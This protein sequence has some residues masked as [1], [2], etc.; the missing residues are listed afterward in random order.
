MAAWPSSASSQ[1][2]PYNAQAF[3]ADALG[4]LGNN[5]GYSNVS[6]SGSR[7]STKYTS[8][9]H[10]ISSY[11]D[12]GI[13]SAVGNPLQGR[14]ISAIATGTSVNDPYYTSIVN[15]AIGQADSG[16]YLTNDSFIIIL[17]PDLVSQ[18]PTVAIGVDAS[19]SVTVKADGTPWPTI[20]GYIDQPWTYNGSWNA[21]LDGQSIVSGQALASLNTPI[22]SINGG[23]VAQDSGDVFVSQT[24]AFDS[25]GVAKLPFNFLTS[26]NA[27]SGGVTSS[28]SVS[29]SGNIDLV[30]IA[31]L[32]SPPP[33]TPI[34]VMAPDGTTSNIIYAPSDGTVQV[35]RR[36]TLLR[37]VVAAK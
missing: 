34:M 35:R 37:R 31:P 3:V 17:P 36:V 12:S 10:F 7:P 2:P 11:N 14:L 21:S 27:F 29:L 28:C 30:A 15:H 13:A 9:G 24:I 8:D 6:A 18:I 5:Y 4:Y 19:L 20:P 1:S 16:I 33:T 26:V 25:N 32:N 22:G 23:S